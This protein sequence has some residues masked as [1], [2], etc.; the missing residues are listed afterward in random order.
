MY[1]KM[2]ESG[3]VGTDGVP[4]L[5]FK[6]KRQLIDGNKASKRNIGFMVVSSGKVDDIDR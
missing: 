3:S 2:D 5:L 6:C 1:F 4:T